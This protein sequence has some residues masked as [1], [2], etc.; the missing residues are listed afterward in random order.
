MI[1]LWLTTLIWGFSF[2]LIGT[3]LRGVDPF[4]VALIRLVLAFCCFLPWLMGCGMRRVSGPGRGWFLLVGG[5]QF[6]GM[7]VAYLSAFAFAPAYVVAL[8]SSFTPLWIAGIG[9]ILVPRGLW[10]LIVAG[11]L[12][13][14]GAVVMR[15]GQPLEAG[16]IWV[17][18]ALMQVANLCFGG[19]QVAWR[20]IVR[21]NPGLVEREVIGWLY[22]GGAIVAGC[23]LAIR[24]GLGETVGV[25]DGRQ[26]LVI[27][28]L[29][30]VASGLGFFWWNYGA[31]RVSTGTLAAANN[32]VVPLGVVLA[33]V[34]DARRPN[35]VLFA[36]GCVLIGAALRVAR[37]SERPKAQ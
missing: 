36:L 6:G 22:L 5:I 10:R 26:L 37:S 30:V 24:I 2:A 21:R 8:F 11:V 28:Y 15:I 27:L 29:G 35:W 33:L 19:G 12:A 34:F 4:L 31:S 13:T 14:L 23:F 3:A 1:Y 16:S 32:L 7:Y 9:A 20:E 17:A 18:F 25:P